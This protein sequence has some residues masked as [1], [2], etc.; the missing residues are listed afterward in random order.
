VKSMLTLGIGIRVRAL[1][2]WGEGKKPSA[3]GRGVT[4][5]HTQLKREGEGV[6]K[7]VF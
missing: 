2:H 5:L 7:A 4:S 6:A 3:G 1:G